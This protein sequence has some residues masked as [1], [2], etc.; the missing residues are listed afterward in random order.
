[1]ISHQ[2]LAK[3]ENYFHHEYN[4]LELH[5]KDWISNIPSCQNDAGHFAKYGRR[6]PNLKT[7]LPG[8][9]EE[10]RMNCILI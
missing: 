3:T 6:S 7:V 8:S 10:M 9:Y 4:G 2:T 5:T 1:M